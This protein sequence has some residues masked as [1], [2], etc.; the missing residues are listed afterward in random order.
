MSKTERFDF[1]TLRRNKD[2]SVDVLGHGT[3]PEP[4]VLAGQP[5]KVFL[6][7]FENEQEAQK[8][9]PQATQ[10]YNKLLHPD[11]SLNH[12]PSEDDPVAGGMYPDDWDD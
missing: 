5:M 7:S 6:D 10:W 12:L 9:Y 3:Y 2:S 8:K 1:Y 11:A 4:S